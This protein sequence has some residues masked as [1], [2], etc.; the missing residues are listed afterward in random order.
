MKNKIP[1]KDIPHRSKF[2]TGLDGRVWTRLRPTPL[3]TGTRVWAV[4]EDFELEAFDL[5]M[6][7]F[8][9]FN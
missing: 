8:Q 2:Y 1:A 6:L 4:N 3:L 5:D 9:I 7:V